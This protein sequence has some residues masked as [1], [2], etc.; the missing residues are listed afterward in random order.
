VKDAWYLSCSP[1]DVADRAALVG[2]PGRVDLF[3][4]QLEDPRIVGENRGLQVVTGASHGIPVTVCAFGMGAPIAVIVL[5]ELAQL[6]V[7]AVVR[8]GTA[9][10]LVAGGLGELVVASAGVREEAVSATYLPSSFPA[11]PDLDL[12]FDLLVAL[13]SRRERY[14]VGLVASLDGFYTEMFAVRPERVDRIGARLGGLR[15]AGVV[16]VDMETSA[17]LTVARRL[18][19]RAASLCL[20]SVDAESRTKLEGDER[21]EAEGRLVEVALGA[22]RRPEGAFDRAVRAAAATDVETASQEV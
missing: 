16:A 20:A 11:T 14:R 10:T 18:G 3:A 9:M 6:G 15:E 22:L 19:V 4:A 17:L 2:D 21:D 1:G 12:L 5:E 8:V 13:E 7:A